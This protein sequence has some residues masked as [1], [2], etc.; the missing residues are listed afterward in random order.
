MQF[1]DDSCRP[2]KTAA[3]CQ[4]MSTDLHIRY[5]VSN[6]PSITS[7]IILEFEYR[8]PFLNC[9]GSGLLFREEGSGKTPRNSQARSLGQSKSEQRTLVTLRYMEMENKL[10]EQ[11]EHALIASKT[12]WIATLSIGHMRAINIWSILTWMFM[13][14]ITANKSSQSVS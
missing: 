10:E 12:A 6:L 13:P 7:Q 14:L 4:G 1:R 8:G 11:N 3:S 2:I 5:T 9:Q